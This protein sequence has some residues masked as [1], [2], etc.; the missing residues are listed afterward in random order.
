MRAILSIVL[1]VHGFAHLVGFLVPWKLMFP[2]DQA[3]TTRVLSGKVDLGPI[4][5]RVWGLIWL[6]LAVGFGVSALWGWTGNDAWIQLGTFVSTVSL[7]MCGMSL[8]SARIGIPVNIFLL[9]VLGTAWLGW[10]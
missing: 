6:G 8:P 7:M 1:A 10:W 9:I 3:Y 4:G 2:S 5:I